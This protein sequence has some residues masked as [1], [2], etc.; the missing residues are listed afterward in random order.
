MDATEKQRANGTEWNKVRKWGEENWEKKLQNT[1]NLTI[2]CF[3]IIPRVFFFY[4]A[5]KLHFAEHV[6]AFEKIIIITVFIHPKNIEKK[7]FYFSR[8]RIYLSF[9]IYTGI[10]FKRFF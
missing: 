8:F 2:F 1:K 7:M 9:F 5:Q 6:Q 4:F 10:Q 3:I